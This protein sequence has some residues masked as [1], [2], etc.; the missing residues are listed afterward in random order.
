MMV[1][2]LI[3][4]VIHWITANYIHF[5]Q[6]SHGPKRIQLPISVVWCFFSSSVVA[7][8]EDAAANT[9]DEGSE[10][11]VCVPIYSSSEVNEHVLSVFDYMF[12]CYISLESFFL[13]MGASI[14]LVGNDDRLDQYLV[15]SIPVHM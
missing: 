6:F 2:L 3:E 11:D 5:M 9:R 12:I 15:T 14:F 13:N 4:D 7:F 1:I 8:C 10:R